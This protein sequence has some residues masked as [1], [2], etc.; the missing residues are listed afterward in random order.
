MD[1]FSQ[2]SKITNTNITGAAFLPALKA[3]LNVPDF[4]YFVQDLKFSE[5]GSKLEA[6]RLLA[7]MK[8]S[9]NSTFQKNAM[10]TLREDIEEKSKLD[11][12]PITRSFIFFE[13]YAITSQETIRNLLIAA[14]AVLVVTS[15]F[16][17]DCTVTVLVVLNFAALICEL[18]GLMVIWDVSL[19]SVSMINLVMAIGFAVDYSAHIAHAYVASTK[20]TANER[21]V[22]ALSTL[23]ASVLMGGFSTFLGMIVLAF[24]AS[25]IFRIFFRMFLG[26]VLFGLL[27]G[28]CIM[29]VYLSLLCWRPAIIRPSTVR[30]SAERLASRQHRDGSNRDLQL[31]SIG[32][33]N[34]SH[35]ADDDGK[36]IPKD[37]E[38]TDNTHSYVVDA[39]SQT[40]IENKG[41][42]TDEGERGTPSAGQQNTSDGT[43][44]NENSE[45]T[46]A[47]QDAELSP[48][49]RNT[50]ANCREESAHAPYNTDANGS[51]KVVEDT[52]ANE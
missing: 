21:V 10:L 28:L 41:M 52:A 29:P 15:P 18:F 11:A 34:Q 25:E 9:G 24:A 48:A 35:A 51:G 38:S 44:T 5:D 32:S 40:G 30:V 20:A 16:L 31:A 22:D 3:F 46:E 4:S 36:T 43:T 13:Q 12:F 45:D 1:A 2:F 27:H 42:E 17:V 23:G 6:S 26:I 49:S 37:E 14:L 19:N 39:F 47:N 8:S 7:F 50:P 33:E